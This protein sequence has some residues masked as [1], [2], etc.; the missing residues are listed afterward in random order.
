M[1][2]YEKHLSALTALFMLIVF[3]RHGMAQTPPE[4]E[5]VTIS[6]EIVA[7]DVTQN[8]I[9]VRLEPAG[10]AGTLTLELRDPDTQVILNA[11]PRTGSAE[12]QNETFD[13]DNWTD[14]AIGQYTRLR[15]TWTVG[16]AEAQ[17]ELVFPDGMRLD[18]LGGYTHT[19][20][21]AISEQNFTDNATAACLVIGNRCTYQQITLRSDFLHQV[22]YN[23]GHGMSLN[24]GRLQWGDWC[25]NNGYPPP[26]ACAP[27]E[28]DE[29]RTFI[30]VD[31][32]QG[33]CGSPVIPGTTVAVGLNR[34]TL[35]PENPDSLRCGERIFI[36]QPDYPE[37]QV[38]KTIT[39]RCPNCA[40]E[41]HVDN[42]VEESATPI[43]YP[44]S[45]L[46]IRLY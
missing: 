29:V 12:I 33:A 42:Y 8:Q 43:T 23:T 45:P 32:Y 35:A 40:N 21:Q 9:Q 4:A 1:K 11:Q 15:A 26:T 37:L 19:Q 30:V 46:T 14:E 18:V 25:A 6:V 17:A 24:H 39:D 27:I 41:R 22:I 36:Y 7:A 38:I 13:L 16:T 34:N 20:Y 44:G 31:T 3:P 10:A 5:P 28:E 2:R